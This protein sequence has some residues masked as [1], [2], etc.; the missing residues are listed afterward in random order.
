MYMWNSWWLLYYFWENHAKV[1]LDF[2]SS[3]CL[4]N[5]KNAGTKNG[6]GDI[7]ESGF[8]AFEYSKMIDFLSSLNS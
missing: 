8:E 2:A 5:A 4:N 3:Y 7:P 6:S 1:L